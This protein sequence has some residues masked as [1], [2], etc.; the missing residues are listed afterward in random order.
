MVWSAGRASV[1]LGVSSIG[2]PTC[3]EDHPAIRELDDAERGA[4]HDHLATE[5]ILIEGTR[6]F[7]VSDGEEA[8][9][10]KPSW[11]AGKSSLFMTIRLFGLTRTMALYN[12]EEGGATTGTFCNS[13]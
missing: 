13:F 10:T 7:I 9:M 3:V 6:A 12:T 8:V 4:L 2:P 1:T 5:H 11:A